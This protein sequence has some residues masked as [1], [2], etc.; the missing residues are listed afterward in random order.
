MFSRMTLL[1]LF[2]LWTSFLA[3]FASSLP[4]AGSIE[5][6][7]YYGHTSQTTFGDQVQEN[8]FISKILD[9]KV[10]P[11]PVAERGGNCMCLVKDVVESLVVKNHSGPE[12]VNKF[13]DDE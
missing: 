9:R 3:G 10:M 7:R 12:L 1:A 13:L 2:S 5:A 4:F 8:D 11:V 6:F